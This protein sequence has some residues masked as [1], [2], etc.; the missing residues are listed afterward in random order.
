LKFNRAKKLVD[1]AIRESEKED[2]FRIYL[3][4]RGRMEKIISF[5]EFATKA[6]F[7]TVEIDKRSDE[8]IHAELEEVLNKIKH[9][10]G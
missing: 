5:N 7:N 9:R 3:V 2:L 6:G 4:D 1:K 8:E 10:E